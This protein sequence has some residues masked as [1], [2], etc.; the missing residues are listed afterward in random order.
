[1]VIGYI[2]FRGVHALLVGAYIGK[3]PPARLIF[4]PVSNMLAAA[5][6]EQQKTCLG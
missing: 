2:V 5:C 3:Y 4:M 6:V 1:M